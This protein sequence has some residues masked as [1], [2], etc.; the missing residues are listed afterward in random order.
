MYRVILPSKFNSDNGPAQE[1]SQMNV[2]GVF[3]L[4]LCDYEEE[5]Y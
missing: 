3:N 5:V 1:T 4:N 2:P